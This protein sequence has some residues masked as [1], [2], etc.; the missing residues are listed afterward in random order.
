MILYFL[1]ARPIN[2]SPLMLNTYVYQQEKCVNF[3]LHKLGVIG[4]ISFLQEFEEP[5]D[6]KIHSLAVIA[7]PI[8]MGVCTQNVI[9]RILAGGVISHENLV[10]G[11]SSFKIYEQIVIQP[12]FEGARSDF[13]WEMQVI[14]IQVLCCF[15]FDWSLVLIIANILLVRKWL[16]IFYVEL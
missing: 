4:L 5:R 6:Y 1:H 8:K 11:V 10:L 12:L 7:F 13:I 9:K 15:Y 14:F 3:I 16:D 2:I